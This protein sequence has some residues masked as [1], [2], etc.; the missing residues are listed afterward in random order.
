MKRS[1]KKFWEI[2]FI[3][4][5]G[6]TPTKMARVFSFLLYRG[7]DVHV[8][9]PLPKLEPIREDDGT[10]KVV[11]SSKDVE[12]VIRFLGGNF[13]LTFA[14]KALETREIHV[15]LEESGEREYNDGCA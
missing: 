8:V 15:S 14:R 4:P 10:W 3:A 5:K 7:F 9:T 12:E 11:C 13:G 2:F 6:T 1:K